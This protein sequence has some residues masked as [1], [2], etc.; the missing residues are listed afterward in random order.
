[1]TRGEL[2]AREGVRASKMAWPRTL[3]F[4]LAIAILA[5]CA[6][7]PTPNAQRAALDPRD[8]DGLGGTG[9]TSASRVAATGDGIGGTGIIGTIS[10]FGSI[11][12]NGLEL[13]FDHTTSV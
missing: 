9:V 7:T 1:M 4:A 3:A 8:G 6:S 11:I 2:A 5:G 12:V 10:G 13:Q